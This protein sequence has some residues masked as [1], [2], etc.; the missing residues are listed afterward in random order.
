ML[1]SY[2]GRNSIT[3]NYCRF[4][5]AFLWP[6]RRCTLKRST[7]WTVSDVGIEVNAGL[8][9]MESAFSVQDSSLPNGLE[10]RNCNMYPETALQLYPWRSA[11]G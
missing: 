9:T 2:V 6:M 10:N 8:L 4:M 11:A 3:C 1:R 5:L 7:T